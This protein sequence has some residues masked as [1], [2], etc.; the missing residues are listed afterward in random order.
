MKRISSVLE[1]STDNKE[2]VLLGQTQKR[3]STGSMVLNLTPTQSEPLLVHAGAVISMLH[4]VPAVNLPTSPQLALDLQIHT[5]EVI[6]T[7]VRTERN[8]QVMC[9]AGLPHELLNH[10]SLSLTDEGHILHPPLQYMFERLAA[11][12][13][14]PKDLRSVLKDNR[15]M[16]TLPHLTQL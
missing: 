8:Q 3:A 12:C 4:L 15:T 14:T 9:E 11:Q 6:R 1:S 7:L 16:L 10:C 5:C 13:L 2:P